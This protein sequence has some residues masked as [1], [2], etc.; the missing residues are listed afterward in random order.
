MEFNNIIYTLSEKVAKRHGHCQS[1]EATKTSLILPFFSALGYDTSDPLEVVPE[2]TCAIKGF[3]RIDFIIASNGK[4]RMLVECKHWQENLDKHVKQLEQYYQAG[5]K[6]YGTRVG[7]LTNGIEYRFFADSEKSNMMDDEPFFVFDIS[8]P[9]DEAIEC[10]KMFHKDNFNVCSIVDA[11]GRM[12]RKNA[13]HSLVERELLTPSDDFVLYFYRRIHSGKAST[14]K[15]TAFASELRDELH[16][17]ISSRIARAMEHTPAIVEH[18]NQPAKEAN[19]ALP[20]N[21]S[22]SMAVIRDILSGRS[23][24]HTSE[25]QSPQ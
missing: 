16:D 6:P 22:E 9:T 5:L 3:D 1:E 14:A 12:R 7:V 25:L 20:D 24:E 13:L 17:F 8:H 4:Y 10:L 11:A 18:I 21:I 19:T 23:E 2:A 15:L